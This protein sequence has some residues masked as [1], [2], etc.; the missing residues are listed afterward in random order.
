LING[1]ET[2]EATTQQSSRLLTSLEAPIFSDQQRLETLFLA[3][4][5][6]MPRD[7][8]RARVQALLEQAPSPEER[9]VVWGDVLWALL[10]ASEFALNH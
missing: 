7:D 9:R 4:L 8:E 10:N 1:S 2:A 6:R 3:T 5:S